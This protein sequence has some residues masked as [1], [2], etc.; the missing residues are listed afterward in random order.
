MKNLFILGV[1]F[2]FLL[3]AAPACLLA[4]GSPGLGNTF[5]GPTN[6]SGGSVDTIKVVGELDISGTVIN[7][8]T[9][10]GDVDTTRAQIGTLN[11]GGI[12]HA[13]GSS[14]GT[15]TSAADVYLSSSTAQNILI[16]PDP[17]LHSEKVY[18]NSSTVGN[19]TFPGGEGMVITSN[20]SVIHG[21]VKGA[22]VQNQGN[23]FQ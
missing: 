23:V 15:I 8:A 14:F 7:Q 5:Y 3:N 12:L 17:D 10:S 19:I 16:N 13:N 1:I 21:V 4:S 11:T 18:L 2:P 22:V 6:C 9:V 20:N